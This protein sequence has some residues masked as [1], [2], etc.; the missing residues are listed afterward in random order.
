[1]AL[2]AAAHALGAVAVLGTGFRAGVREMGGLVGRR[3]REVGREP[4]AGHL[5]CRDRG[6][7]GP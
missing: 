2:F 6:R 5:T 4:G 1:M 7:L 3:M